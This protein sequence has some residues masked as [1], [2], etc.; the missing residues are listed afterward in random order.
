[1]TRWRV[2]SGDL[3]ALA[4]APTAWEAFLAA[5]RAERPKSLGIIAECESLDGPVGDDTVWYCSTERNLKEAGLW[6][7]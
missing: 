6:H 7:E 1:M 2:K 5:V 3:N 4:E